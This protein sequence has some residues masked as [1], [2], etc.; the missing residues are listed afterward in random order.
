MSEEELQHWMGVALDQAAKAYAEGE[1]P[2]GAAAV[3]D[4]E[5]IAA[6]HNRSIQ[7]ND[8]TAH[9]EVLVLRECGRKLGNYRLNGLVLFTTVEP[10]AMCAGALVWARISTVVFGTRDEKSGA[11]VSKASLLD[12]GLFNHN[13]KVVEGIQAEESRLILRRFFEDRRGR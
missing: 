4:G 5:L 12:E 13:V 9:C 3:L 10:C 6:D 2:I 8:P 7:L 11:V 1:V